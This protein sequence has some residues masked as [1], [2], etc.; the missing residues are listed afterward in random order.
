[1]AACPLHKEAVL[2][3]S[4]LDAAKRAAM[5]R[6]IVRDLVGIWGGEECELKFMRVSRSL[7]PNEIVFN[8]ITKG[9]GYCDRFLADM[10]NPEVVKQIK[11]NI[12]NY[13]NPYYPE[14]MKLAFLQKIDEYL[15]GKFGT[16]KRISPDSSPEVEGRSV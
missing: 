5:P 6:N 14:E 4:Y 2:K 3:E 7:K 13:K 9:G 15:L 8:T 11:E 16:L 10:E 12:E 1:M